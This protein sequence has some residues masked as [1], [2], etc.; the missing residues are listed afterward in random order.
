MKR[1]IN[2]MPFNSAML[3]NEQIKEILIE[4][5]EIMLKKALGVERNILKEVDKKIKLP[6]VIVLTG[7]R[8]SG[9][10]TL[11]RQI[12]DKH[13]KN[14]DFFYVSFEDER[15]FNFPATEFNMV[16]EELVRLYGRKKTFFIDEI[17]NIKNF[18]IFV[19][20]FY[21]DGFKFFITGSSANLLSRELGTK[22]TGRHV[23][24]T[25]KPFSFKEFLK[26]RNFAFERDM[27]YKT[28]N[29]AEIRSY[30]DEYLAKGGM[31][32][33]I[34]YDAAELLARVYDDTVIKDIAVRHK[35]GNI[36]ELK[37]LYSFLITNSV[38]KFSFNSLKKI[39]HLGSVN[40]IKKYLSYLEET[41]FAKMVNKFDYSI[42]KQI[43]NDK[44]VYICDNG[45]ITLLSKKIT[46]DKGWLLENLVFNSFNKNCEVFYYSGKKEC[47]F[48]L[49][50]NRKVVQAVQ[51][52]HELNEDNRKR[53]IS[54]LIEAM[55]KSRLKEGLILT[56]DQED[57]LKIEKNEIS[58]IPVWKWLLNR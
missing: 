2:P 12:I 35:I 5:R 1:F 58:I 36:T 3:T 25:L 42:K 37:E 40:T 27:I 56:Y 38:N 32:E 16:Y 41:H 22:L 33:Y 48:L 55:E 20:R 46:K 19:R 47:D 52:C 9:K 26:L 49:L 43:I 18:E 28:E 21:E 50:E 8:R 23:D 30:F 24:I 54:G 51:V 53:E 57:K 17:Q 34:T 15:L 11:L 39:V 29:R 10:S 14:E 45:F 31:P 7:L 6:H 13:Y 44:K 4:Q